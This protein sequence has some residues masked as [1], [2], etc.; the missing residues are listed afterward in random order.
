MSTVKDLKVGD[1]VVAVSPYNQ[2]V[3]TITEITCEGQLA[4]LDDFYF[5][6]VS[7]LRL[8]KPEERAAGHRLDKCPHGYDVA[9][10]ICGFGT[11]DGERIYRNQGANHE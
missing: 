4:T 3:V 11:V 2:R 7:D 8:A 5:V 1:V 10:L 9:C 6:P